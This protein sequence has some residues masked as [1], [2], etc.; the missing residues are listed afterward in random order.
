MV[1]SISARKSAAAASAYYQ[2]MGKDTY[3]SREGEAPGRWEGRA[4]ERLSLAGPVTKSDFEAA[5]AGLDPKTGA[6]LI[7]ANGRAHAAGWDMTFSAPKSVSVLWAL[8]PESE[9][10]LIETFH[11]N[12]VLKA[13]RFLEDEAALARRGK[14]GKIQERVAGLLMAQFDHHTSRDLD[15]QLHTH[16]FIFNLAPRRDG[17]WGAIVSRELYRAQK[18][19][20]GL[21]RDKLANQLER[22]GVE[23]DRTGEIFRVKAIPMMIEKAFSK[24]RADIEKAA[25]AHGYSTPKGMEMAA[26]RTR[27]SKVSISRDDLFEAWKTEAK[28]LGFELARTQNRTSEP[29]PRF[30]SNSAAVPIPPTNNLSSTGWAAR[31]RPHLNE[32]LSRVALPNPIHALQ[33]LAAHLDAHA[34][35]PGVRINL[36]EK[37]RILDR[38]RDR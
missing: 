13:T 34:R 2:H 29:A 1:A 11:T 14:G 36:H 16:A 27:R 38:D 24:R 8:S 23:I 26:L 28:S 12:A 10:K 4:A 35:M 19:A 9:R 17:T 15:P 21:Y 37:R 7:Q 33:R 32:G 18:R 20:G 30:S 3:Y 5:L 22:A 25:E 6:A 31:E